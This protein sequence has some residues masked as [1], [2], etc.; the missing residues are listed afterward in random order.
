M[1]HLR[2][3]TTMMLAAIL[4]AVS[5]D[6]TGQGTPGNR[7]G[8][9]G[10]A[11]G[12][13]APAGGGPAAPAPPA[14]EPAGNPPGG[15]GGNGPAPAPRRFRQTALDRRVGGMLDE[16]YRRR[17]TFAEHDRRTLPVIPIKEQI[18]G[19]NVPMHQT[20]IIEFGKHLCE[21]LDHAAG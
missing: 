16:S 7:G 19:L 9:G 2:A 21:R 17:H 3:L 13:G 4:V 14:E 1:K 15:N 5:P 12:G 18:V 11:G 6:A 10:P 8:G 20:L